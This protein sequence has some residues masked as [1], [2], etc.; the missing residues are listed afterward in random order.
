MRFR[1]S[2]PQVSDNSSG[3]IHHPGRQRRQRSAVSPNSSLSSYSPPWTM[4]QRP[5]SQSVAWPEDDVL[6]DDGEGPS[7][8]T[9]MSSWQE[10]A[11]WM[12]FRNAV[13]YFSSL[14]IHEATINESLD[15]SAASSFAPSATTLLSSPENPPPVR[16][17]GV[18][19]SFSATAPVE[20]CAGERSASTDIMTT[21]ANSL[22]PPLI[23]RRASKS[24][25]SHH[26]Q[27]QQVLANTDLNANGSITSTSTKESLAYVQSMASDLAETKMRLALAQAERD[28]LEFALISGAK[29]ERSVSER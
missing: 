3:A 7:L 19:S 27:Q 12:S 4:T 22:S 13:Q 10:E 8:A 24:S 14:T 17:I 16:H 9:A 5:Q 15:G 20:N 11:H 29:S 26:Q 21:P 25:S 2:N 28:E 1:P 6:T 18:H 23:V